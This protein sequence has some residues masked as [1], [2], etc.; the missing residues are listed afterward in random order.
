M[1]G[2]PAKSK[3]SSDGQC[4]EYVVAGSASMTVV[5]VNGSGGS[6]EGWYKIFEP[7]ASFSRVFAYNRPG[8]GGS[9]RPQVAQTGSQMVE[10]L[11]TVLQIANLAPP[12]VLVGHSLGGLIVN[13]FA[14]LH[15]SEVSAVVLVEATAP[16]D[17]LFLAEHENAVQR[18]LR[19]LSNKI[20]PPDPNA[21]IPHIQATVAELLHAPPFPHIPLTVISG[22]KSAMAWVTPAKMLAARGAH[23]LELAS[24]SPQGKQI[25]ATRS[26]HFPQFSEP[27]LLVNVIEE[28]VNTSV[29][30]G[31]PQAA[32]PPCPST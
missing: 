4:I 20:V 17:V 31:V 12:Y 23:Q 26:G 30:R 22:E 9:S 14:R 3:T 24:L 28:A 8:I 16:K 13:L 32:F 6:I 21:E 5:L 27:G 2:F 10:S 19:T 11:R 29:K 1:H 18:F 15:P 7:I 25:M